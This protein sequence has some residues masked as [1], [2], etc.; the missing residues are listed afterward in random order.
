MA[1]FQIGF[2]VFQKI[3]HES[4]AFLQKNKIDKVDANFLDI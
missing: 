2:M 3:L 4:P 1:L